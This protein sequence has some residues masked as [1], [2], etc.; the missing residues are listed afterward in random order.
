MMYHGDMAKPL[1]LKVDR[2]AKTPAKQIR[3]EITT[4]IESGVLKPSARLPSWQ[5]LAAR[6]GVPGGCRVASLRCDKRTGS[7]TGLHR[8]VP[9]CIR[10]AAENRKRP[11]IL[12]RDAEAALPAAENS[13]RPGC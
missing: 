2:S 3:Y 9:L 8:R 4:A 10:S 5:E 12:L 13:R 6:L 11:T 7:G 1:N